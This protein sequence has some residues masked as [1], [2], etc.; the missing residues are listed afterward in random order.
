MLDSVERY[1]EPTED[2]TAASAKWQ[3]IELLH[4]KIA[5][6]LT[7]RLDTV[8]RTRPDPKNGR[9]RVYFLGSRTPKAAL[10]FHRL[11]C[12]LD[13]KLSSGDHA[14]LAALIFLAQLLNDG[15]IGD[16]WK[17]ELP[18]LVASIG[19]ESASQQARMNAKQLRKHTD[20]RGPLAKAVADERR[21]D[22]HATCWEVLHRLAGGD[23]VEKLKDDRV[24]YWNRKGEL[25]DIGFDR[26]ETVYSEQRPSTG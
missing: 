26:F 18:L 21:K 13:L 1:R 4:R 16:R 23:V 3:A 25:T 9:K 22:P 10:T 17:R 2:W 5:A 19:G 7:H 11:I 20:R 15:F 12:G 6:H 8:H 24:F 14:A